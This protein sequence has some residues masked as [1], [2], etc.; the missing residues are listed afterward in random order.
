MGTSII[1]YSLHINTKF[2]QSLGQM[3]G[4]IHTKMQQ[5]APKV[6]SHYKKQ[7]YKET[8]TSVDVSLWFG[9]FVL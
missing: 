6:N 7:N 5:P 8:H 9:F 1:L 2:T 4:H 3:H